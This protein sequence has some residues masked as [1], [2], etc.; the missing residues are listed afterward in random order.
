MNRIAWTAACH[1]VVILLG[2]AIS[3]TPACAAGTPSAP[4]NG[5]P[6]GR[7]A[8]QAHDLVTL[9]NDPV[10][11][12]Q[13]IANLQA[14]EQMLPTTSAA[15]HA[16]H[17]HA[18]PLR[19]AGDVQT[20]TCSRRGIAWPSR[21]TAQDDARL[22]RRVAGPTGVAARGHER[23]TFCLGLGGENG[24]QRH[25][26]MVSAA[27]CLQARP[28]P[29]A[30]GAG[31]AHPAPTA[32][33]APCEGGRPGGQGP[34]GND[35]CRDSRSHVGS[36]PGPQPHSAPHPHLSQ[37]WRGSA[38]QVSLALLAFV[39]DVLPVAAFA[40]IGY[41]LAPVLTLVS[42]LDANDAGN[43]IPGGGDGRYQRL[44]RFRHGAL[45]RAGAGRPRHSGV[46]IGA[47]SGCV[48]RRGGA[49]DRLAGRH[50]HLHG[51]AGHRDPWARLQPA[52]ALALQKLVLL[53]DHVLLADFV[54]RNRHVVA[55][56]LRAPKRLNGPV[57]SA[58]TGLAEVW[59]IIA[60][61][62]ILALRLIWAAGW[63]GGYTHLLEF[64]ATAVA[65][66]V[67]MRLLTEGLFIALRHALHVTDSNGNG[68]QQPAAATTPHR[69]ARYYKLLHASISALAAVIGVVLLLQLTG[70]GSV[71]WLFD[72]ALGRQ[73]VSA[74]V[75]I[76][77]RFA[78]PSLPGRRL[79][80]WSIG[81]SIF[82]RNRPRSRAPS[83]S[84]RC[85]RCCG[86]SWAGL[87]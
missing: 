85:C 64:V 20:G 40:V 75:S 4:A 30:G 33:P 66:G 48:L 61:F 37:R 16:S 63:E 65:I 56:R 21:A 36:P 72:S 12:Q 27:S 73:T 60:V 77:S 8:A 22:G 39:L 24:S 86:Q 50:R 2:L 83:G 3:R 57:A 43:S 28:D 51:G 6:A 25:V 80:S 78:S 23:R 54:L 9:L 53:V 58:L 76:A 68:D 81:V 41:L 29:G 15:W 31:L 46:A 18:G 79:T 55:A 69:A 44:R 82:C 67:T 52:A 49:V 1:I 34:T 14:L 11:R 84:A 45:H 59:H 35:A 13:L 38:R 42:A 62:L 19:H 74:L 32:E 87:S 70:V 26:S 7:S 17:R 5:V 47:H 71:D 10:R